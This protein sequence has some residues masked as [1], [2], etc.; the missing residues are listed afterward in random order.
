MSKARIYAL[1]GQL[2]LSQ[3]S[4]DDIITA[5]LERYSRYSRSMMTATPG[6]Y[7][8]GTHYGTVTIYDF[9]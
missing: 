6:L 1:G 2:G 3:G 9:K 7:K 4:I 8:A 5:K